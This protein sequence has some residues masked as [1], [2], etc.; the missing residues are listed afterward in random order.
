[1]GQL[2]PG[3]SP[4]ADAWRD[5]DRIIQQ[6]RALV[7]RTRYA[8]AVN[9]LR[10]RMKTRASTLP[11]NGLLG[12]ALVEAALAAAVV[13]DRWALDRDEMTGLLKDVAQDDPACVKSLVMRAW[14]VYAA[15][16]E[17]LLRLDARAS[18]LE[19]NRLLLPIRTS[20]ARIFP[21]PQLENGKPV[22]A[23]F[24]VYQ[25]A[26]ESLTDVEPNALREVMAPLDYSL[27]L[28]RKRVEEEHFLWR[29]YLSEP[30]FTLKD[31]SNSTYRLIGGFLWRQA[32]RAKGGYE[33]Q[34]M[35]PPADGTSHWTPMSLIYVR[36]G[37]GDAPPESLKELCRQL[38]QEKPLAGEALPRIRGCS[39]TVLSSRYPPDRLFALQAPMCFA[40][41][42]AVRAGWLAS[43]RLQTDNQGASLEPNRGKVLAMDLRLAP[44][45]AG[46][47]RRW[48]M[49]RKTPMMLA[50]L[51]P[52][53]VV[54]EKRLAVPLELFASPGGKT[55][56]VSSGE[57][58]IFLSG[59][60]MSIASPGGGAITIPCFGSRFDAQS[61]R[62]PIGRMLRKINPAIPDW[63]PLRDL[64]DQVRR[65][66][67]QG[68]QSLDELLLDAIAPPA[69]KSGGVLEKPGDWGPGNP[70]WEFVLADYD[71][72]VQKVR[73]LFA[74]HLHGMLRGRLVRIAPSKE[75][76]GDELQFLDLNGE[77]VP[78]FYS[79]ADLS[80]LRFD[81]LQDFT[82]PSDRVVPCPPLAEAVA[83]SGSAYAYPL[84]RMQKQIQAG[85]PL[86]PPDE[87]KPNAP[88]EPVAAFYAR[89]RLPLPFDVFEQAVKSQ[90]FLNRAYQQF[91]RVRA[92]RAQMRATITSRPRS[93][94]R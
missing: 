86:M 41:L 92:V 83:L 44:Q 71:A 35:L 47:T 4:V 68:N 40:G 89:L 64:R 60:A 93:A 8:E 81:G 61:L 9:L 5:D 16:S 30:N 31:R 66:G 33:W 27:G 2:P 10:Q 3:F 54:F 26:I 69:G 11:T 43:D 22:V 63:Q 14:L 80:K 17:E 42:S 94:A 32:P 75:A 65:Y 50:E 72:L 15:P 13:E 82:M 85:D 84:R 48:A 88:R 57:D 77:E 79:F 90:G 78:Q 23:P 70:P 76:P 6:A 25:R 29:K 18:V 58:S 39:L 28:P 24:E 59:G 20:L 49:V 73:S 37:G 46:F 55:R 91:M 52:L 34:L 67:R 7:A 19:R 45:L 53:M 12:V 51:P 21:P 56:F 36:Y 38:D 62:N 87:D 1:M 74:A